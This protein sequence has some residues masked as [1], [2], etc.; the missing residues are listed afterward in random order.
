MLYVSGWEQGVNQDALELSLLAREL[1]LR[2]GIGAGSES[3]EACYE[4]R[5]RTMPAVAFR[6]SG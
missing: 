6:L 1:L 4:N 5:A 2:A 3:K